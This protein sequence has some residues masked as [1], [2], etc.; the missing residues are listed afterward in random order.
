MRI[1]LDFDHTIFDTPKLRAAIQDIFSRHGVEDNL[2]SRTREESRSG[3]RNWKPARQFE[4]LKSLGISDVD[5]I[6]EEFEKIMSESHVFLYQDTIPFLEKVKK[7]HSLA[8]LTYG[9]S[10]YQEM[11]LAGCGKATKYFDKVLITQNLNKDKEASDLS[12]G[13][14]T[15]FVE[16]NPLAL[17]ATKKIAPHITTIRINRGVGRYMDEPSESGIDYDVTSLKEVEKIIYENSF[18]NKR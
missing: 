9:E 18:S 4:I 14:P 17:S 2:F 13:N 12:E 7:D 15:I 10:F 5:L 3:G 8:L 16:D 6:R 1:I 11:K